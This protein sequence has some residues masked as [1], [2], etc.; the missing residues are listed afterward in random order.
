MVQR[1]ICIEA[2]ILDLTS[3]SWVSW[4]CFGIGFQRPIVLYWMFPTSQGS[5]Q[6][7]VSVSRKHF[8]TRAN[9]SHLF[10]LKALHTRTLV[11]LIMESSSRLI[12]EKSWSPRLSILLQHTLECEGSTM[13]N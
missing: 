11:L 13:I 12:H 6:P 3:V 10:R 8:I 1:W 2:N 5:V 9:S 7:Q 4:M